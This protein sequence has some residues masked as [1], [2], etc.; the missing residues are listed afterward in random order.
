M[1]DTYFHLYEGSK[2]QGGI[3][4]LFHAQI[5][6][7]IQF[8]IFNGDNFKSIFLCTSFREI[9][10]FSY[11]RNNSHVVCISGGKSHLMLVHNF[12][13][14]ALLSVKFMSQINLVT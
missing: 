6:R 1:S 13:N 9:F 2:G 10:R 7:K 14:Y 5:F 3:L 11:E 12:M 8:K 4:I